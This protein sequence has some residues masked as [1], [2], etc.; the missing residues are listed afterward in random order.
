MA[1]DLLT[2]PNVVAA[3][4]AAIATTIGAFLAYRVK[5][6]ATQVTGWDKYTAHLMSRV[7]ELEKEINTR[8]KEHNARMVS[9]ETEMRRRAEECADRIQGL[10][11]HIRN[12]ENR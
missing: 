4:V 3:L 7:L 11:R 10:E 8:D 12:L 2:N 1:N 9:L 6:I 5:S